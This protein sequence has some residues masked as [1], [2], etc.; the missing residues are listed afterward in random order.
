MRLFTYG[1]LMLPEVMEI[2]AGARLASEAA[3]LADFRA[4]PLRGVVYPGL[5]PEAGTTTRGVLWRGLDRAR[6]G[7]IDRF[8]GDLYARHT[9]AVSVADGTPREAFVYVIRPGARDLVGAGAWDVESF[10]AR[11]LEA[12]LSGCRAF[13]SEMA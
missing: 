11:E 7:R 12:Y 2:V 1:T 5:V 13:A 3:T 9:L 10:R 4:G 8:E 6:L